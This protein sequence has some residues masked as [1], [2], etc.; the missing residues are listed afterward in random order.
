MGLYLKED[1]AD[2]F[3][4]WRGESDFMNKISHGFNILNVGI[5]IIEKISGTKEAGIQENLN[6][7]ENL[8][9]KQEKVLR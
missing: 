7:L 2:I 4:Y 1:C 3:S 6:F 8:F 5:E 9:D